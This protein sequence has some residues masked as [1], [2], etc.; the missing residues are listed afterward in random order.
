MLTTCGPT[1]ATIADGSRGSAG[2]SANR[3][4]DKAGGAAWAGAV[5][6]PSP[7]AASTL[8]NHDHLSERRR[9]LLIP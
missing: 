5:A 6:R 7:T 2:K 8:S 1:W 3:S 9:E 4:C